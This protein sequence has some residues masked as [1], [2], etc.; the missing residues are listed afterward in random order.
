M[1]IGSFPAKVNWI[2]C[3][4]I[5]KLTTS[6][7]LLQLITGHRVKLKE[8]SEVLTTSALAAMTTTFILGS[9]L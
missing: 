7:A 6:E 9:I 3:T 5:S 2:S 1:M 4:V 8:L